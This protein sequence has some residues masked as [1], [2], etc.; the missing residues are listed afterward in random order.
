MSFVVYSLPRSRSAWL[1]HYLTYKDHTCL[2]EPAMTMRHPDDYYSLL[3]VKNV[4]IADTGIA[5]GWRLIEYACPG[6][7]TVVV[8][9]P[10]EEAVDSL[11]KLDLAG[12]ATYEKTSLTKHFEYGKRMLDEISRRSDVLSVNFSDLNHEE[13]CKKIFQH[14]LPYEF[15]YEHWKY[16]SELNIQIDVKGMLLYY[17]KNKPEITNFKRLCKLEMIKLRRQ[18]PELDVWKEV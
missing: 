13:V 17:F 4:G 8:H 11:M 3:K 10:V 2:H 7:K 6:I 5:Q 14:C 1:S 15:D 12:I 9:R 18:Y 16:C